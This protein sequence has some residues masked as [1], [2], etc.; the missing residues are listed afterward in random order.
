MVIALR[1][2]FGHLLFKLFFFSGPSVR[3]RSFIM[4][5]SFSTTAFLL[6][7]AV[8]GVLSDH[9]KVTGAPAS[10]DGSVPV[11]RSITQLQEE[12]GPQW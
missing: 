3:L 4:Q 11:R 6:L 12:A 2:L 7:G 1:V 5:L 10:S 9:V 8:Q